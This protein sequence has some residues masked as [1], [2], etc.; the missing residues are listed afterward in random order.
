MFAIALWDRKARRLLLAR[1]RLGIKPIYYYQGPDFF[2]F[3]SEIKALLEIPAVPC[4]VDPD[5]LSLYISLRF[6]PGPRTMFRNIFKLQPGHVLTLDK[7]GMT[8]RKYWDIA[9]QNSEDSAE[10]QMQR[11]DHM[12]SESVRLRL[13]AD[14]PLGVFLSG[15][16]DSSAILATMSALRQSKN[17][18]TFSV[19]YKEVSGAEAASNE[20]E[21]AK[22]SAEAFGSNHHECRIGPKEFSDVLSTLVWHLDEP[23]ADPTC[24]PLYFISR[25]ARQRITVVLSGEGADEGFG[26]YTIYQRMLELES[27]CGYG[28]RFFRGMAALARPLLGGERRRL[29][30]DAIGV[31]LEQRY[32]GVSRAFT[33]EAKRELLPWNAERGGDEPLSSLFESCFKAAGNVS[34]LNRM[35]YVDT[36]IW[37]PDDLL[38]KADKVTMAHAL[39]LRVPFLDHRL[40]EFAATLPAASKVHGGSGK[41]LLRKLMAKTLPAPILNRN[42]KGF[43]VPMESWLRGPLRDWSQDTLLA[44]NSAVST[45]MN[46]AVV[47]RMVDEHRH[48]A[49]NRERELWALLV[50]EFWHRRFMGRTTPEAYQREKPA[51]VGTR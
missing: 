37:L 46:T 18:D 36:H 27:F 30:A 31:P 20:F 5:A 9:F 6:V 24:V 1:D 25:A 33:P 23:L 51:Q 7:R 16:L 13:I 38:L 10:S 14:V 15:G 44:T 21:Y 3:A 43:P 50:F 19:G 11:L 35:L 12:L 48:G 34:P 8:I 17:I 29:M 45:Y 28:R 32:R 49:V 42:K 39:E 40:L 22:L 47:R 4:D 41:V 2:A 26:G